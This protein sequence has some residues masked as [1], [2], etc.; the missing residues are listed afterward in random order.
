MIFVL[1]YLIYS[2]TKSYWLAFFCGCV[3]EAV[4][5]GI[6]IF[7]RTAF[8]GSFAD[9]MKWLSLFD[10]GNTFIYSHMF[11]ITSIV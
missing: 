11:G 1:G 7:N 9:V 10:R 3:A 5:L 2:M 8:V 4:L 6:Y